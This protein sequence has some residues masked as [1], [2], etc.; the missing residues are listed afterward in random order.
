VRQSWAMRPTAAWHWRLTSLAAVRPAA[1]DSQGTSW[2][3]RFLRAVVDNSVLMACLTVCTCQLQSS[4]QPMSYSCC[5][6]ACMH[7]RELITKPLPHS[8]KQPVVG[9]V[10]TGELQGRAI[11][12]TVPGSLTGQAPQKH[13][14][15]FDKV[16]GPTADQAAVF[17]EISELIQSALDGHKV[18]VLGLEWRL[19]DC[20]CCP[21]HNMDCAWVDRFGLATIHTQQAGEIHRPVLDTGE[22][23]DRCAVQ[24]HC[25]SASKSRCRR[26]SRLAASIFCQCESALLAPV[27][28]APCWCWCCRCA[29]SPMARQAVGR[30]TPCLAT[31]TTGASSQGPWHR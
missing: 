4:V 7:A 8:T 15:T 30:H 27:C 18:R 24:G 14:F 19:T 28:I 21:A 17:E 2:A 1:Y 12:I 11:D 10:A 31:L 9:V 20:G 13:S 22:C 6:C 29:S 5:S 25:L 16:F 23:A 3:C 26:L